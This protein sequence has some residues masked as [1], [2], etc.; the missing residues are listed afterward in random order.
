MRKGGYKRNPVREKE[1]IAHWALIYHRTKDTEVRNKISQEISSNQKAIFPRT[2]DTLLNR[3]PR[4]ENPIRTLTDERSEYN[5]P[6]TRADTLDYIG[7][8][9]R[10]RSR[11][12]GQKILRQL[13][14]L[15]QKCR[16]NT[17][18]RGTLKNGADSSRFTNRPRC[19]KT[20]LVKIPPPTNGQIPTVMDT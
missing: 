3:E 8:D 16:K 14:S 18:K 5:N 20:H 12:N 17:I 6:S 9:R 4:D 15:L 2:L 7:R 19:W 10:D 11:G 13:Q 1:I